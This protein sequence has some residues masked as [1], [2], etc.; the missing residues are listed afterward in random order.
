MAR[1]L[2]TVDMPPEDARTV[3]R[4]LVAVSLRGVDTHGVAQFPAYL[5][6][7]REGAVKARPRI[8]VAG[9]AALLTM[10]ADMANGY[11]AM[12]RAMAATIERARSLGAAA[13][14]VG[15]CGHLGALGHFAAMAAE[16]GMIGFVAQ[17]GPTLMGPPGARRR[18]IGNNPLA[19]AMPAPDGP[20]V[21]FDISLSEAAYG[22]IAQ[23]PEGASIPEGWA[24]DETGAPTTNRE[25]A[26]SGILLSLGGLK[27]IGLA[28]LVEA[29]AG[30]L[31]GTKP[32]DAGGPFG[33]FALVVD[34]AAAGGAGAFAAHS[35]DWIATYRASQE[36][37]RYP[38]EGAARCMEERR[39]LGV[40]VPARL[41]ATLAAIGEDAGAA[42][43][44]P[45]D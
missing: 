14:S 37:A 36:G 44:E 30:G 25:A 29:L 31:S 23:R 1:V 13:I 27:G 28:M 7:L 11:V 39:A 38:G 21:V 8:A 17:N 4:S 20:P 24:L 16:A 3:G 18:A 34:P 6:L 19:F 32:L 10:D 2:E 26:L 40:P 33:G 15:R 42:F 22:K 35:A 41:C 12:T 43:P 5:K 45:L 9:E